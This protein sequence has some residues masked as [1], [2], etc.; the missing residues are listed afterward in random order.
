MACRASMSPL[1]IMPLQIA[2][3]LLTEASEETSSLIART[4]TP[5]ADLNCAATGSMLSTL[6]PARTRLRPIDARF[7]AASSPSPEWP[8]VIKTVDIKLSLVDISASCAE[9]MT[10]VLYRG[11][12]RRRKERKLGQRSVR[13]THLH[14]LR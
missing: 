14:R 13:Q 1:A 9:S 2:A 11:H 12:G 7:V 8:P 5:C 3:A 6:R 10:Q 4:L